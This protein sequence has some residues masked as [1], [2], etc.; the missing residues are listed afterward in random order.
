MNVIVLSGFLVHRL[1]IL[2][3][4]VC[5]ILYNHLTNDLSNFVSKNPLTPTGRAS[6]NPD[7]EF[8]WKNG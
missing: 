7:G 3:E 4:S 5:E 2:L 8:Q 6:Y 1:N